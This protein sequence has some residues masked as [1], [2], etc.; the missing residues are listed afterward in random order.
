MHSFKSNN[1]GRPDNSTGEDGPKTNSTYQAVKL[2]NSTALQ[3]NNELLNEEIKN[4][5]HSLYNID[6]E[7]NRYFFLDTKVAELKQKKH[8]FILYTVGAKYLLFL[9]HINLKPYA[10][11]I[12]RKN[13]TFFLVKTRFNIDLYKD[14]L[15]EGES[16]KINEKWYFMVSDCLVHKGENILVKNFSERYDIIN[17]ILKNDYVSDQFMEPFEL[18]GKE[19]FSY[20]EIQYVKENYIPRMPIKITGYIFK[21][22]ENSSYDIIYIFP[23]HR[24]NK[25]D[26]DFDKKL[27]PKREEPMEVKQET[28]S[29]AT[30]LMRKTE[31]PDA[32]ELYMFDKVRN[33]KAQIGYAGILNI[34]TSAMVRGWFKDGAE[35]LTVKFK[36]HPENDKWIPQYVIPNKD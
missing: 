22:E 30:Y 25:E 32:Y 6:I 16:V 12:H 34:E 20:E 17:S 4:K 27:S 15:L 5:I 9:T 24:K 7:Y 33:K 19:K 18:I 23:E 1:R 10:V 8:S 13:G 35:I 3:L 29:E 28:R 14:T 11:Y 21:C 31:Y 36:R 26:N 2:G